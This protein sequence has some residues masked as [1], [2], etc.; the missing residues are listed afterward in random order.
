MRPVLPEAVRIF[1]SQAPR[2]P[3]VRPRASRCNSRIHPLAALPTVHTP[4]LSILSNLN[5]LQH[6][7]FYEPTEVFCFAFPFSFLRREL[8]SRRYL[9]GPIKCERYAE[10]L[11][12]RRASGRT[13][14]S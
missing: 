3:L 14:L 7:I 8:P 13:L 11:R 4:P 5:F 10:H 2:S 1:F 12:T 9:T 6:H